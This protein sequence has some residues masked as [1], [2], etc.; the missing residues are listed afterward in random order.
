MMLVCSM[1]NDE[2]VRTMSYVGS[3]HVGLPVTHPASYGGMFME[4]LNAIPQYVAAKNQ[5]GRQL[6]SRVRSTYG[7]KQGVL[8]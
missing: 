6:G 8:G 1:S 2:L 4:M 5:C 7:A 3:V